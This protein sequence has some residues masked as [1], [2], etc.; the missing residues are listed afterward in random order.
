[1]CTAFRVVYVVTES[2]D[3]FLKFVAVLEGNLKLNII[4]FTTKVNN[5]VKSLSSLIDFLNKSLYSF[6]L[7]VC[8]ILWSLTS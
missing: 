5:I 2:K 4:A 8:N 7:V 3:V 1:M 6:W